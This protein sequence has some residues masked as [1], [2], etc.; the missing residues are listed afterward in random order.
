MNDLEKL[1]DF[2]EKSRATTTFEEL[3]RILE[4]TLTQYGFD[5]ISYHLQPINPKNKDP[6]VYCTYAQEW[7]SYYL[8]QKYHEIDPIVT[9][10]SKEM[11]PF[12]WRDYLRS[13]SL[14]DQQKH[15]LREGADYGVS[16]G[17]T[18]PIQ[19]PG[20][21]IPVFSVVNKLPE[22]EFSKIL[23]EISESL[24]NYILIFNNFG[25]N[26]LRPRGTPTTV[27]IT[28]REAE[29]LTWVGK[30]KTNWDISQILGISERTVSFHIENAKSKF[31][32]NTR[33]QAVVEALLASLIHP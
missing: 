15:F 18:I 33:Q 27:R 11:L 10:G 7:V 8:D 3:I 14:S 32:V 1:G 26:L 31:G 28:K 30:G 24:L 4:A 21:Y 19:M 6:I 29:C 17:L 13:L 9:N 5:E 20:E 2:I 23:P 12:R 25:Y 22:R 16:E